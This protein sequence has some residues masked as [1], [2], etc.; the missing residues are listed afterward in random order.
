LNAGLTLQTG[1]LVWGL[2]LLGVLANAVSLIITF[3]RD[4]VKESIPG[5]LAKFPRQRNCSIQ[6][7]AITIWLI[8]I[9][10]WIPSVLFICYPVILFWYWCKNTFNLCCSK[11][12]KW[13]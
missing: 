10:V 6:A 4:E 2:A 5:F 12:E 9:F 3:Y 7:I 13:S 8:V 1:L 11:E